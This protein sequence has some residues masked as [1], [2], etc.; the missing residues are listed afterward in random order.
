[1][2]S[3]E[4][5]L[6]GIGPLRVKINTSVEQQSRK[7]EVGA[8]RAVNVEPKLFQFRPD[9]NQFQKLVGSPEVK[10]AGSNMMMM[11]AG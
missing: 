2:L 11:G 4:E 1:V 9:H 8:C 10:V 5:T 6:V 3:A 7:V